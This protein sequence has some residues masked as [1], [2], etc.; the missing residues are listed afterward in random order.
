MNHLV[1]KGTIFRD[2]EEKL[3]LESRNAIIQ[4]EFVI[5]TAENWGK[6]KFSADLLLETQRLAVNQIYRCAGHFRDGTV[7]LDGATHVPPPQDEVPGLV[8]EMCQYVNEKWAAPPVHLASYLMWRMNWIHPF[9]GGNGR[10]A[11]AISYLALCARLGFVLPGSKSIP[12]L[13]LED[14]PPYYSALRSADAAW[15]NGIVDVSEMEAMLSRLLSAQLVQIHEQA[16][17][18]KA[19]AD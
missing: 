10:T 17:G 16:T 18:M 5:Y 2:N 12:E 14:R 13:I 6:R 8:D 4:F 7:T 3:E 1:P 19:P 15:T 11:R 9:Y